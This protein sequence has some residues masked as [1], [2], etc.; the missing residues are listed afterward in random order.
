ML[1]GLIHARYIVTNRGMHAMYNKFKKKDFG[2]CP[3]VFCHG[4][5]VLPAGLS[6][7]PR[8]YTVNLFCP[9]CHDIFYPKSI[10]QGNLDGAYFGTTFPHLCLMGHPEVIPESS[11]SSSAGNMYVPKVYGF[12]ISRK[13]VYYKS[14][15][16]PPPPQQQAGAGG[17]GGRRKKTSMFSKSSVSGG[18]GGGAG[19]GAHDPSNHFSYR[20]EDDRQQY[21]AA[22]DHRGGGVLGGA[23][24]QPRK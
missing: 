15:E 11:A 17:S 20:L 5:A 10:R 9:K 23:V 19:A 3:R 16:P 7:L 13:S 8:N 6:D 21:A 24:G 22:A 1:Y 12:R 4:Q 14:R 18:G 2:R